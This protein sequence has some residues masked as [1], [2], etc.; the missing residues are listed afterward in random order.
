MLRRI[1]IATAFL[2]LFAA[3][4]FGADEFRVK[5]SGLSPTTAEY[6]PGEIIVK[7]KKSV[8]PSQ[9]LGA[10]DQLGTAIISTNDRIGFNLLSIPATKS[11][12][13]MAAAFKNLPEVEYA[14]PNYIAHAFMTP[15][16]PYYVY[17]WHM[18]LINTGTAWDQSTGSGVVVA[19]IDAGVAYENFGS[20][21][22]APDLAGTT[23]VPGWDFV[24]N[25]SHPNDDNA[26]GTHVAG[27]IA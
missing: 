11:V 14:E 1:V 13:E 3:V 4:G 23:F 15:N 5:Q 10:A 9:A 19:V 2:F 27:T 12:E 24:N 20:F 17:Q 8:T 7:F 21:A 16:D 25:D 6:V 26:H 22:Q 18:P